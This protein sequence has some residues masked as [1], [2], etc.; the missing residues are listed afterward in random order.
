MTRPLSKAGPRARGV[1]QHLALVEERRVGRVQIL[2]RLVGIERAPTEGDDA[3]AQIG[4]R[5]ND[6][7]AEAV[8]GDGDVVSADQHAGERH[9]IQREARLG[10]VL[11]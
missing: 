7:V 1:E 6:A 3:V 8:V 9:L 11:L 5:E 2:R 10:E 4:D